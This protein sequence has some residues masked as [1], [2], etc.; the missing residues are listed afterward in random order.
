MTSNNRPRVAL[1]CPSLR[2]GGAER[3][4]VQ[5]A[6]KF[7]DQN[8]D[9]DLVLANA[10]GGYL[11]EVSTKVNIVDLKSHRVAVAL[12]GMI[13]Y[14]RKQ[15]PIAM[16]ST[17]GEANL[18]AVYAKYLSR[19]PVRLLL[20]EAS[21][22]NKDF[23]R[24]KE[25]MV[26]ELISRAYPFASGFIPVSTSVRDSMLKN[27]E[28]K[29]SD[30]RIIYNP[31]DRD[32]LGKRS[33]ESISHPWLLDEDPVIVAVGRLTKSKD[34][35]TL[36]RS[37]SKI[38]KELNARLI[39]MGEGPDRIEIESLIRALKLEDRIEL[40][41]FVS[42]PFAYM[43]RA[44]LFVLS[45]AWEGLPNTLIQAMALN[46]R[47]I[48]TDCLGGSAEILENGQWGTLVPV[49]DIDA[50]AIAI[51]D[52]LQNEDPVVYSSECLSRF[53]ADKSASEYLNLLLPDFEYRITTNSNA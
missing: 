46:L 24:L 10:Q 17:L 13:K 30:M 48:A 32:E 50:L 31:V 27:I 11:S 20:R 9:V 40:L 45:S 34:Y 18:I 2:G 41:G 51:Q 5:L 53:D 38:N 37:F 6:N 15:R 1:F 19:V 21:V 8:L 29:F 36:I 3:V 4:M 22:I 16:L 33:K 23:M 26:F 42:N 12:P 25:R 52:A 49:G 28:L 43:A 7:A 47:V 44:D 35:P 39:I 14:L